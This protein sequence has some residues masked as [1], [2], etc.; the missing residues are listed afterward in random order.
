MA[1]GTFA[2]LVNSKVVVP[3]TR[4]DYWAVNKHF[5]SDLLSTRLGDVHVD[6]AWYL[7]RY[8]DVAKAIETGTV[9]DAAEHYRKFGY[10][11]HRM[12]MR[13]EVQ[14]DWYL[15]EYAD[16][17]TAVRERVFPSAQAHFDLVGYA[18]GR[19]PW[20]GFS[21][22]QDDG[23]TSQAGVTSITRGRRAGTTGDTGSHAV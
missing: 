5:L 6:Q 4:N 10:F 18:E 16:V 1:F 17:G 8:P 19:L 12:P 21:L 7:S 22:R 23:G 20:A 13:I 3:S 9:A 14:E 15:K 11:E 2:S